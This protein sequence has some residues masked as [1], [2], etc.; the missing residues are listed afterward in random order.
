MD[1]VRA[2][3]RGATRGPLT[4][5]HGNKNYYKGTRSGRM[6][7]WTKRGQYIIEPWR[8]RQFVVPELA[9]FQL[10]PFVSPKA[11]DDVRKSHSLVDYFTAPESLDPQLAQACLQTAEDAFSRIRAPK[12]NTYFPGKPRAHKPRIL[13]EV[14]S[15]APVPAA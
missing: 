6:G 7:H 11:D 15:V 9:G 13:K 12:K 3:V 4:P 10:K 5:K 14:S 8:V 2:L 1:V